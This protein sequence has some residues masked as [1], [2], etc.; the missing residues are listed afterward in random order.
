M[1]IKIIKTIA[2]YFQEY[3]FS[4]LDIEK[5]AELIIGRT[6][7]FGTREELKWLFKTYGAQ[8][9]KEFVRARGY[10]VLSKRGFNYWRIVLKIRRYKKPD[11][12]T[13]KYPLWRY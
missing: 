11:W 4:S 9:I 1:K 7:E 12:L 8:R 2:P 5:D 13:D 10:R 6:L 3:D